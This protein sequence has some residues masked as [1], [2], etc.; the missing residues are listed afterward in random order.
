VL[1]TLARHFE[2]AE[3]RRVS[4]TRASTR[5]AA[6]ASLRKLVLAELSAMHERLT[7]VPDQGP[8]RDG[9]STCVIV[10][11]NAGNR[12]RVG[13]GG[14]TTMLEQDMTPREPTPTWVSVS[15]PQA[16][17]RSTLKAMLDVMASTS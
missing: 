12:F 3:A 9:A 16:T 17:L 7:V 2:T 1:L 8:T 5:P 4:Q 10:T 6:P 11:D 15:S 13:R 14:D